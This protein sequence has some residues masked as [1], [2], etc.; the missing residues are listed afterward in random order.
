MIRPTNLAS[1]QPTSGEL[2]L[3]LGMIDEAYDKKAW[4]GPNLKGSIRRLSAAEA[5]WRPKPN[6]HS[7]AEIVAHA[8]YWKYAIRRRLR[9]DKR[10]SFVLKGSNWFPLTSPLAESSW[11]E[12]G[13][14]LA[15]EHRALRDS[16]AAF[17][18]ERLHQFPAGGKS[19]SSR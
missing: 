5:A 10:G 12:P 17:P 7:I 8:A 16:V 2:L 13:R 15:Q 3:L 14:A 19:A 1:R 11:K 4:H 6:R 18:A 9:G